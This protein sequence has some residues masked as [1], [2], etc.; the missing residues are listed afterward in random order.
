MYKDY[1]N[2]TRLQVN[3]LR[4]AHIIPRQLHKKLKNPTSIKT[5]PADLVFNITES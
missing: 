5:R 4:Q 1:N 3:G 2:D